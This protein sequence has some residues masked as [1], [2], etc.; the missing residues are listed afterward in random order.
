VAHLGDVAPLIYVMSHLEEVVAQL[1]DVVAYLGNVTPLKGQC[2][3]MVVEVRP[4]SGR[5]AL[6]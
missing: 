1:G 5:L 3:K 2:H 4:W 6:N